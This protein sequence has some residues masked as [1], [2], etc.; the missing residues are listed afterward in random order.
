MQNNKLIATNLI[1]RP[2]WQ[3]P[4]MA[5]RIDCDNSVA[6]NIAA[7]KA[8]ESACRIEVSSQTKK[9]RELILAAEIIKNHTFDLYF[10]VLPDFLGLDSASEL[11]KN[12]PD[13]YKNATKLQ[14]FTDQI[15]ISVGGRAIHPITSVV[16]GFK[17]YP[18]HLDGDVSLQREASPDMLA[19]ETLRLFSSFDL[20]VSKLQ[21]DFAALHM[22]KEYACYDGEIWTS[23]GELYTEDKFL[24]FAHEQSFPPCI[25]VR[26]KLR[27]E[28]MKRRMDPRAS[29]SSHTAEP[30]DDKAIVVGALARY[31]LNQSHFDE[32][33][34]K[35]LSE[36]KIEKKIENPTAL[37]LAKAIEIYYF[38]ILS[39]EILSHS[40]K[41]G[42]KD[43]HVIP[44]RKFSS[45]SSA[46]ESAS[47][48]VVHSCELDK[49][50]IIL[51]Y[52]IDALNNP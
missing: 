9:L 14:K 4:I 29:L 45:G 37:I 46:V 35:I 25:R 52:E 13:L 27:R 12:H 34:K 43:E 28:S 44:P 22:D 48:I 6:H 10:D 36:L 31:N 8:I 33:T 41:A 32:K 7:A 38:V 23:K 24:E 39:I 17:S 42:I 49:D 16:G 40:A 15:L 18:T 5:A 21:P 47:G 20:P 30:E 1:G 3:A 50:G 11:S 19:A 2:Y 51:K 26:D